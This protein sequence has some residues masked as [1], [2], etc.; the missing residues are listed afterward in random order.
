MTSS[1]NTTDNDDDQWVT[2]PDCGG[3]GEYEVEI[4][5]V[6]HANGGY[7]AGVM[8]ECET[9]NGFGEVESDEA[10][11]FIEVHLEGGDSYH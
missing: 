1:S 7:L 9:C 2:C 5:V 8:Q 4:A 6:D 10:E 11:I 3:E